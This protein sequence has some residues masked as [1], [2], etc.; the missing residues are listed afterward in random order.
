[1]STSR[2]GNHVCIIFTEM[3]R[4]TPY[5]PMQPRTYAARTTAICLSVQRR[6][7]SDDVLL[8]P[9]RRSETPHI[10]FFL[11]HEMRERCRLSCSHHNPSSSRI[12][13]VSC[14]QLPTHQAPNQREH[15][16][17]ITQDI[18]RK[19][20]SL[21]HPWRIHRVQVDIA[22]SLV[23][24]APFPTYLCV[25][26][27]TSGLWPRWQGLSSFD[28]SRR[29]HRAAFEWLL[30]LCYQLQFSRRPLPRTFPGFTEEFRART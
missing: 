27:S 22:Q 9:P 17:N 18:Y 6:Y 10:E 7:T 29:L 20:T 3:K 28:E 26:K 13:H 25:S 2:R 19:G 15:S 21:I 11:R 8:W 4:R 24:Q 1:M 12:R 16:P 23:F 5:S 30:D 14:Q